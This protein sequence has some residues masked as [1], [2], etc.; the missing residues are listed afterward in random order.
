M[1]RCCSN[2]T[3]IVLFAIH[4]YIA[5]PSHRELLILNYYLLI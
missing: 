4:Y 5:T 3:I 2:T 1:S